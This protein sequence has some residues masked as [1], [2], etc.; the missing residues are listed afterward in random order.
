MTIPIILGVGAVLVVVLLLMGKRRPDDGEDLP[1]VRV[2]GAEVLALYEPYTPF[3]AKTPADVAAFVD[4]LAEQTG[5]PY[6]A[7]E[8]PVDEASIQSAAAALAAASAARF[9][10]ELSLASPDAAQLDRLINAHL[11]DPGLR[12]FLRAHGL[13]EDLTEAEEAACEQAMT[14]LRIP[15][16]PLLYYCLGCFWGEWLCRHRQAAWALVA[17]LRPV[18]VFPHQVPVG[19]TVC[20][21]PFSQVVR[22][23]SDPE[24]DQLASRATPDLVRRYFPPLPLLASVSDAEYAV[25]APLPPAA[26]RASCLE[27]VGQMAEALA[28]YGEALAAAPDHLGLHVLAAWCA[29]R[30]EDWERAE[31]WLRAGLALSPQ[32]PVLCHRLGVL[33]SRRPEGMVE[34]RH[35]LQTAVASLPDY[36]L[37]R[38]ALASLHAQAGE[39][40]QALAEARW[41]Q[42]NDAELQEAAAELL[43]RLQPD[44]ESPSSAAG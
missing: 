18:Q 24:G 20:L 21:H 15:R 33:S 12:P 7:E 34:A 2:E 37:A 16:E 31:T 28:C 11:V 14:E 8:Y 40:E 9:G 3:L 25:F 6:Q 10:F 39:T 22:K 35:L 19:S 36:G 32:H 41:V 5:L 27:G 30:A 29:W 13:R 23:L 42:E 1:Y 43:A 4:L 17:P 26:R 38:L 44:D